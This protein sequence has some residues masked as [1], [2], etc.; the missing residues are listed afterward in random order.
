MNKQPRITLIHA[1]PLSI[2]PIE[3]AFAAAWPQVELVN[4]LE[5]S[6]SRDR[7]RDGRLSEAM[8]RRFETLG[9]YAASIGSAAILFTC[10]AFAEAIERVQHKLSIPVLKPNEAMLEEAL[11]RGGRIAIV[12]T[13]PATIDSMSAELKDYA[14]ERGIE[15]NLQTRLADGAMQAL[16]AGDAA[17]HDAMIADAAQTIQ[18][19]DV[20]LLAQFSMA[21]ARPAVERVVSAP[22][23]TS[24][25]SAVAKLR[26]LLGSAG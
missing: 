2:A 16:G 19:A 7:D 13:F 8:C 22:V 18:N 25:D 9:D 4:L 1:T 15:L 3:Q 23:L 17:R 5:D 14:A 11:E 21:R 6:L 26:R 12:A 10:S 24:P 20:V